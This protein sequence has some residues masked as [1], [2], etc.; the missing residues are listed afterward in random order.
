[1]S[2]KAN[3]IP[4]Q[5]INHYSLHYNQQTIHL[6]A[7]STLARKQSTLAGKQSTLIHHTPRSESRTYELDNIHFQLPQISQILLSL[8]ILYF[9]SAELVFGKC[10]S[11]VFGA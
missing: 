6:V 1:M 8:Q 10:V 7:Q 3:V 2:I 9:V 4:H 11:L 5:A